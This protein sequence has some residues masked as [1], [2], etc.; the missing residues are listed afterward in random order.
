MRREPRRKPTDE[1]DSTI[2]DL[3]RV[4]RV[5]KGGKHLRFRACIGLGD[6]K[7]RLGIGVAKGNDVSAAVE[8]AKTQAKKNLIMVPI[9]DGTIPHT[10]DVKFKAAK[11]FM[12]PAA[13]GVGV[14][15]GGVVRIL[16]NLA[17]I[18]DISAKILGSKSKINNAKAVMKAFG[19]FIGD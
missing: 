16:C 4:T 10:I 12:K 18:T 13:S 7:G 9:L 15:A 1:F 14:K 19:N 8:K 2:L 3:A 17:G 11:I 6:K 5:T